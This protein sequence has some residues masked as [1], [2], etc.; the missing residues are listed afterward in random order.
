MKSGN[1]M[2]EE[3]P[4][5]FEIVKTGNGFANDLAATTNKRL[6]QT[7]L[8]LRQ[9]SGQT[10][11]LTKSQDK[12]ILATKN[13]EKTIVSLDNENTRL[14]TQILKLTWITAILAFIQVL[15]V[16]PTIWNFISELL[17]K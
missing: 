10:T 1:K 7:I 14:N 12:S 3:K 13:L 5:E 4:N 11:I 15:Q 16:L 2:S 9:L 17:Q 8:E 6:E